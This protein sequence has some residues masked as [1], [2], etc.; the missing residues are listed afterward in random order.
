MLFRSRNAAKEQ[1]YGTGFMSSGVANALRIIETGDIDAHLHGPKVRSF[2]DNIYHFNESDAVTIDSI[3]IQF[4][5][6]LDSDDAGELLKRIGGMG[7]IYDRFGNTVDS[8]YGIYAYVAEAIHLITEEWNQSHPE[9]YLTPSD[10]Q[11]IL[12]FYQRNLSGIDVGSD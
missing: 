1:D 2:F 5:T 3:M 4:A 7:R 10:V 9:D 11:A 6:G 8:N 12:W